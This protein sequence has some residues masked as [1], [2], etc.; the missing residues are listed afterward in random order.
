MMHKLMCHLVFYFGGKYMIELMKYFLVFE[1]G[2]IVGIV[3]M[4]FFRINKSND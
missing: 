1:L 4:C 3:I 2:V